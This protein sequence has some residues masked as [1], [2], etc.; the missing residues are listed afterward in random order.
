MK[1]KYQKH[2][3]WCKAETDARSGICILC[4]AER[5]RHDKAIDAGTEKYVL[6]ENRPG[7]RFY[8][9][10]RVPRTEAQKA[11][12]KQLGN[13][14]RAAKLDKERPTGEAFDR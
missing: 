9:R 4:C 6:P 5:D 14:A 13:R 10:K 2:C 1:T 3:R 12:A 11:A 8:E 7:H